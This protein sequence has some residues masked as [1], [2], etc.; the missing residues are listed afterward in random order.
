MTDEELQKIL[1]ENALLFTAAIDAI[2]EDK[3]SKF[4]IIA[5]LGD[6]LKEA[7]VADSKISKSITHA[8]KIPLPVDEKTWPKGYASKDY[9]RRCLPDFM[10]DYSM[11][12]KTKLEDVRKRMSASQQAN[13]AKL[14]KEKP[15]EK[16][17]EKEKPKEKQKPKKIMKLKKSK[18][19]KWT[20]EGEP[21]SI[22]I[23]VKVEKEK[24]EEKEEKKKKAIIEA[25]EE[26]TEQFKELKP[27]ARSTANESQ[28]ISVPS[29]AET[30]AV[31]DIS[32]P[33]HTIDSELTKKI[34]EMKKGLAE[35]AEANTQLLQTIDRLS[36]EN[37]RLK[38]EVSAVLR[39]KE[40]LAQTAE[41]KQIDVVN[42]ALEKLQEVSKPFM[43]RHWLTVKLSKKDDPEPIYSIIQYDAFA[44]PETRR[45]NVPPHLMKKVSREEKEAAKQEWT[46]HTK[47]RM[48][49]DIDIKPENA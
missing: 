2:K 20:K 46:E 25:I 34:M 10:K 1:D 38:R 26:E 36:T 14:K 49:V 27:I 47:G 7:G 17:I 3:E 19:V 4:K 16:E 41:V 6:Q 8:L 32:V 15:K 13:A 24:K 45:V 21:I 40:Q 23:E 37:M 35:H 12:D 39:E 33:I 44:V 18:K 30:E 48:S 43:E 5:R 29:E 22:P 28:T 11:W 31:I 42:P 9:I